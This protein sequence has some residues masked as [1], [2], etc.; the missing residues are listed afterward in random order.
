M[1]IEVPNWANV[2]LFMVIGE[3]MPQANEDLAYRSHLAFKD[4]SA[5]LHKLSGLLEESITASSGALP[6]QIGK[7]YVRT[8]RMV[9]DD[10]GKN[11]VVEF[12]K[13]MDDVAEG[14]VKASIQI[15]ENKVNILVELVALMMILTVLEA[16]SPFVFGGTKSAETAA[17][18]ASRAKILGYLT[19]FLERFKVL[20]TLSEMLEE[21]FTALASRLI[22]MASAAPGRKPRGV[23]A[24]DLFLNGAAGALNSVFEHI[25]HGGKKFFTSMFKGKTDLG[26]NLSKKF[27]LPTN[28]PVVNPGGKTPLT[29]GQKIAATSANQTFDAASAGVSEYFTGAAISG[30]F[31]LMD[32]AGGSVSTAFM[33][34]LAL[35]AKGLGIKVPDLSFLKNLNT[36]Q[37]GPS[38]PS[39]NPVS[40][41]RAGADAGPAVQEPGT[42]VPAGVPFSP[43]AAPF[44]PGPTPASPAPV[45]TVSG[46][47][48]P[49]VAPGAGA[50]A[51]AGQPAAGVPGTSVVGGGTVTS[52]DGAGLPTA[53]SGSG[54]SAAGPGAVPGGGGQPVRTAGGHG[55]SDAVSGTPADTPADD[56]ADD[57]AYGQPPE[58]TGSPAPPVTGAP[59]AAAS[60][61]PQ[62]AAGGRPAHT[63][64]GAEG[65]QPQEATGGQEGED[66]TD[67]QE[68]ENAT[69]GQEREDA[70]GTQPGSPATTAPATTASGTGTGAVPASGQTAPA[71]AA[72][73]T[74]APAGVA[75]GGA[76]SPLAVAKSD[77][78]S[79]T[80]GANGTG[81]RSTEHQQGADTDTSTQADADSTATDPTVTDATATDPTVTDTTS[82]STSTSTRTVPEENPS[83][84]SVTGPPT[85]ASLT[86]VSSALSA[87]EAATTPV[88]FAATGPGRERDGKKTDRPAEP[89]PQEPVESAEPATSPAAQD[90]AEGDGAPVR[91]STVSSRPDTV[92]RAPDRDTVR[93][94]ADDEITAPTD[95]APE[96]DT[97]TL[98]DALSES[99]DTLVDATATDDKTAT[100][101]PKKPAREIRLPRSRE[102]IS[103]WI[104]GLTAVTDTAAEHA[105]GPGSPLPGNPYKDA[106]VEEESAAKAAVGP[107]RITGWGNPGAL[108][109]G[110]DVVVR[111]ARVD[112]APYKA[113]LTEVLGKATLSSE[114][115]E[116]LQRGL[117][118]HGTAPSAQEAH[119]HSTPQATRG[120]AL[121]LRGGAADGPARD[122][123][124]TEH[125]NTPGWLPYTYADGTPL[126]ASEGLTEVRAA[127]SGSVRVG[128]V[129]GDGDC[130]FHSFLLTTGLHTRPG[131]PVRTAAELR[132]RLAHYLVQQVAIA[133]GVWSQLDQILPT[134]PTLTPHGQTPEQRRADLVEFVRTPGRW[135][136]AYGDLIPELTARMFGVHTRV[137]QWNPR[138][139]TRIAE[140]SLAPEATSR[141]GQ[142]D[143]TLV[144]F[145]NDEGTEHWA[146]TL[147]YDA[148]LPAGT[149]MA[150]WSPPETTGPAASPAGGPSEANPSVLHVDAHIAPPGPQTQQ[151]LGA[152]ALALW[153]AGRVPEEFPTRQGSGPALT[154][155]QHRELFD[156]LRSRRAS[157]VGI[158]DTLGGIWE[159][160][161]DSYGVRL[162]LAEISRLNREY[163]WSAQHLEPGEGWVAE[164]RP[165]P[166]DHTVFRPLPPNVPPNDA[167][168]L[169]AV[170]RHVFVFGSIVGITN[171]APRKGRSY[172]P[173]PGLN[174]WVGR[175]RAGVELHWATRNALLDFGVIHGE[176]APEETGADPDGFD[177]NGY[178]I[179]GDASVTRE[180]RD[181]IEV[182]NAYYR[183]FPERIG[184]RPPMG[185]GDRES[186]QPLTR[187]IN[188]VSRL[189]RTGM[190]PENTHLLGAFRHFGVE[191]ETREFNGRRRVFLAEGTRH[192]VRRT[193]RTR[194]PREPRQAATPAEQE[195]KLYREK[196]RHLTVRGIN[197]TSQNGPVIADVLQHGDWWEL[198][199][200]KPGRLFL[201][202]REETRVAQLDRFHREVGIERGVVPPLTPGPA[203]K[204]S[205]LRGQVGDFFR[206]LIDTGIPASQVRLIG[207]LADHGF[208]LTPYEVR[209]GI[210]LLRLPA[211]ESGRGPSAYDV[212]DEGVPEWRTAA[213]A[214]EP[215]QDQHMDVDVDS[216]G[217]EADTTAGRG[218]TGDGETGGTPPARRALA[219][220]W[221][222]ES[223]SVPADWTA[224]TLLAL[225][226][227]AD[228]IL[229]A[230]QDRIVQEL[231]NRPGYRPEMARVQSLG[232][233]VAQ[234]EE[235]LRREV[236]R[237]R[238][239]DPLRDEEEVRALWTA[240]AGLALR[241]DDRV[242]E[243]AV[244]AVRAQRLARA[245]N[246]SSVVVNMADTEDA[247]ADGIDRVLAAPALT[248]RLSE[249]HLSTLRAARGLG[250]G[251]SGQ[252]GD[253]GGVSG[254]T[255]RPQAMPPQEPVSRRQQYSA[256]PTMGRYFTDQP[257]AGGGP[258]NAP[259]DAAPDADLVRAL[260]AFA[261]DEGGG[262]VDKGKGRVLA[263]VEEEAPEGLSEGLSEAE[264]QAVSLLASAGVDLGPVV[265]VGA[266][267]DAA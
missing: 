150:M 251:P 36:S 10:G 243:R 6:P 232:H 242:P 49:S 72:G 76:H 21:M 258:R 93:T 7:Q 239:L 236:A 168:L 176:R 203:A 196:Y 44:S 27:D 231:R 89:D 131:D 62:T 207:W 202:M 57:A 248:G 101:G 50:G 111:S 225:W 182:I 205:G 159:H 138:H 145:A 135:N 63:A 189:W 247:L 18:S 140:Y 103:Q 246:G 123:S 184:T 94:T 235:H 233:D 213:D 90:T 149:T 91:L 175:A 13:Q 8:T 46:V 169:Q 77:T 222:S 216:E 215:A 199:K 78:T 195:R 210:S 42:Q 129:R 84:P 38:G 41:T 220:T 256:A 95:T 229:A 2:L 206:H 12:A 166:P 180:T 37:S 40:G 104:A 30:G 237:H 61:A 126:P 219:E 141:T 163:Q 153:H 241:G 192:A 221:L 162:D 230:E 173:E 137:V 212:L 187:A 181:R 200:G 253:A 217:G 228:R 45:R 177:G 157:G 197:A 133:D 147:P 194:T 16:L 211:P 97:E 119:P 55:A 66:A 143:L 252:T 240:A 88:G 171:H 234:A 69:D 113:F 60:G 82:T 260:G 26:P 114:Q 254:P 53:G 154:T 39:R 116:R 201:N 70:P 52:V 81:N 59:G 115:R 249:E 208:T 71:P 136:A 20:P 3:R 120:P 112:T 99:G 47:D 259:V 4:F 105:D 25:F 146:P 128:D 148:P 121:R 87:A 108:P 190:D 83:D 100:D 68:R 191:M 86:T 264:R 262:T 155:E 245:R 183:A 23:D 1:A 31:N 142:P 117:D 178:V 152:E 218:P 238:H 28:A 226:D 9:T 5:R 35:G 127:L 74:A 124:A 261:A 85:A 263:D 102:E 167:R 107:T 75:A 209:P 110:N 204:H 34:T 65:P 139:A 67:G 156:L 79:H 125:T 193:R 223:P 14:R 244:T 29:T 134:L 174:S 17:I 48:A 32:F 170:R 96:D 54:Q 24:K 185:G 144:R 227:G 43:G 151:L 80:P 33:S 198:K 92:T 51:G 186:G 58:G 179:P 266:E 122:E 11:Y 214:T 250:D 22:L 106:R 160:V 165:L 132:E 56:T 255:R 188:L 158:D 267:E 265:L 172:V 130:F 64:D 118:T 15:A 224:D 19:I 164:Y 73:G 161:R 98:V 109:G 257:D